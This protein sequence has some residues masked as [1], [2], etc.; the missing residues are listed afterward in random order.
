MGWEANQGIKLV[1]RPGVV[2][3]ARRSS[4]KEVSVTELAAHCVNR[5]APMPVVPM[6]V[7]PMSV[8]PMSVVP[9]P[10]SAF[11]AILQVVQC[12]RRRLPVKAPAPLGRSL[13]APQAVSAM[14]RR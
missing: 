7:V 13:Y 8:V 5:V 4:K 12:R 6:S 2:K 14:M 10:S 1:G 11:R 9:T 3:A